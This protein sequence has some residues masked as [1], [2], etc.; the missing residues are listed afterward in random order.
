MNQSVKIEAVGETVD[1]EFV[2]EIT[3]RKERT[4]EKGQQNLGYI[5][6]RGTSSGSRCA[7]NNEEMGIRECR[8][9]EVRH[10]I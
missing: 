7:R 5:Y 1:W 9:A 6:N 4:M 3:L 2:D 8:G 10:F